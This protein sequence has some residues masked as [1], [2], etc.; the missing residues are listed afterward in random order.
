MCIPQAIYILAEENDYQSKDVHGIQR[1]QAR[2]MQELKEPAD[3]EC[4]AHARKLE[5]S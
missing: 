2:D 1:R 3:A 5:F 4:T